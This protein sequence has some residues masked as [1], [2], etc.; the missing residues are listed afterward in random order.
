MVKIARFVWQSWVVIVR[1]GERVGGSDGAVTRVVRGDAAPKGEI[2]WKLDL[3]AKMDAREPA[4]TR[5][6]K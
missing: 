6:G 5:G 4:R 1:L 3:E 2:V